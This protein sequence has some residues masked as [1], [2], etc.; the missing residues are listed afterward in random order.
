[1]SAVVEVEPDEYALR[2][3]EA[4]FAVLPRLLS[5]DEIERLRAAITAIPDSDAVRRKRNVY[6]VRNLLDLS[7]EIRRLAALPEVR[8]LVTPILGEGAFAARA[9][10]FDKVPG[11]NWALGWHQDSVIAVAEQRDVS[12]FLAWGQKAGVW[13]VQ[14]PPEILAAMVAVRIH[15]DDCGP[16]NGPLRVIPGS[17]RHGWVDNEIGRWKREVEAVTCLASAGGAVV[18]CPLILHASSK[19]VSPSH[20]RVIHIEYASEEL[21]GGLQWH[22]RIG[23]ASS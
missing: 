22:R 18:M 19:A 10:F 13:Q 1:M 15:L 20:R 23:S 2:F 9:I 14:P 17:H 6:G 21:P 16:E 5:D 8:Q 12:G 7:P 3:H 4:G 11:A